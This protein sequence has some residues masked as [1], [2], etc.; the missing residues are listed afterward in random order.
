MLLLKA[1]DPLLMLHIAK[2]SCKLCPQWQSWNLASKNEWKGKRAAMTH[3]MFMT[4]SENS[5]SGTNPIDL[6][7]TYKIYQK[8]TH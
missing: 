4:R 2:I 7:K 8:L 1:T 5:S 3:L 6:K